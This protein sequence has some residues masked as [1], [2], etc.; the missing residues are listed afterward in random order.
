MAKVAKEK[1]DKVIVGNTERINLKDY[2]TPNYF[3]CIIFA[4]VL[5]HLKDPWTVLS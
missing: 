5:E 2:F 4:D 3:D 1:I